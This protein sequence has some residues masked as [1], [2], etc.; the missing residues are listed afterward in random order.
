VSVPLL[1]QK[2]K[3]KDIYHCKREERNLYSNAET[4][5]QDVWHSI[6]ISNTTKQPWTT[7]TVLVTKGHQFV[8][9]NQINFTPVGAKQRIDISKALLVLAIFEEGSP[10]IIKN[11]EKIGDTKY[12]VFSVNGKIKVQNNLKEDIPIIVSIKLIGELK[13]VTVKPASEKDCSSGR[14]VNKSTNVEWSLDIKSGQ[15]NEIGYTRTYYYR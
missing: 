1:N 3:Y 12:S 10:K 2:L 11:E 15:T 8:C 14:D 5:V 9:N 13:D 7:G 4:K 6:E